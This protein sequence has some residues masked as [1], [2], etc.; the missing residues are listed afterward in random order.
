MVLSTEPYMYIICVC[1]RK[2]CVCTYVCLI[3]IPAV[4]W[5]SSSRRSSMAIS[6]D[7]PL[8]TPSK[9][10]WGE[11][12]RNIFFMYTSCTYFV[13]YL[14]VLA[15]PFF[16]QGTC[17]GGGVQLVQGNKTVFTQGTCLM[18]GGGVQL[19]N[20]KRKKSCL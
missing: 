11:K 19:I 8:T 20:I 7:A 18:G 12:K 2:V 15:A 13:T 16:A 5:L 4:H 9:T 10:I 3:V 14:G 6:P 17:L 1:V